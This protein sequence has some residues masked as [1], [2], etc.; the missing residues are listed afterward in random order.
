[1]IEVS[2][3]SIILDNSGLPFLSK[4]L[5]SSS[6]FNISVLSKLII[7]SFVVAALYILGIYSSASSTASGITSLICCAIN[8]ITVFEFLKEYQYIYMF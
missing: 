7:S 6:T 2:L 3:T 8:P 4:N 5:I 1:M